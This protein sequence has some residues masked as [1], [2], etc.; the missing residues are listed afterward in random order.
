MLLLCHSSVAVTSVSD[1]VEHSELDLDVA[2]METNADLETEDGL[3]A[4]YTVYSE[5]GNR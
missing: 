5:G 1:V 3:A 4:A 2:E